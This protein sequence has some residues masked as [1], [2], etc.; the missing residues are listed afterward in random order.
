M[1]ELEN[2]VKDGLRARDGST[3]AFEASFAKASQQ[4]ERRS[5]LKRALLPVAAAAALVAVLVG[6]PDPGLVYVSEA[7][8]FGTTAWRAPS[9]E[10]LPSHRFNIYQ[11]LPELVE[12][13]NLDGETL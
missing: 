5:Q 7:E 10:L 8:L 1:T 12:S 11:D 2:R 13:T 6:R 3:P 9:D 4:V